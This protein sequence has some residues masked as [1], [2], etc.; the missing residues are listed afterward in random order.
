[1]KKK[2]STVYDALPTIWK[3]K[4]FSVIILLNFIQRSEQNIIRRELILS[5]SIPIFRHTMHNEK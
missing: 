4:D 2:V 3:M 5:K 1:M